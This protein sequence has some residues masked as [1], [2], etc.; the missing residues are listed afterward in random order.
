M[1]WKTG[2]SGWV[3]FRKAERKRR[4]D[5]TEKRGNREAQEEERW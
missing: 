2:Y 1:I 3:E 4:N 5:R